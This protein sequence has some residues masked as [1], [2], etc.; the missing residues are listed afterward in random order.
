MEET[1]AQQLLP[2]PV[3]HYYQGGSGDERTLKHCRQAFERIQLWPAVLRD[4]TSVD[5]SSTILGQ[6]SSMPV[7]VGPT[8]RG[9]EALTQLM[10]LQ[11]FTRWRM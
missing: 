7:I 8:G 6:H 1:V 4:V 5:L 2:D 3:W 11:H 10:L 9:A